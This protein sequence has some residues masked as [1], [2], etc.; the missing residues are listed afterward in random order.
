MLIL[1]TPTRSLEIILA[2]AVTTRQLPYVLGYVDLLS[3][4]QAVSAVGATDGLT[5]SGTAVVVLVAP[6]TG[7][8]RTVKFLSVVN[9]D[10][11]PAIVTVQ[12]NDNGTKVEI[13]TITLAVGDNLVYTD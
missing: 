10:T 6:V 12:I 13:V 5:T 7:H 9:K 1:D 8:T 2:G 11:V 3:S 4:T